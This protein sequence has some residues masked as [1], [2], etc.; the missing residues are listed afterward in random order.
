MPP[1]TDDD[2]GQDLPPD[3][4]LD[5]GTDKAKFVKAANAGLSAVVRV[6]IAGIVCECGVREDFTFYKVVVEV[7]EREPKPTKELLGK[8]LTAGYKK[9]RFK[10]EWLSAISIGL[11]TCEGPLK[12]AILKLIADMVDDSILGLKKSALTPDIGVEGDRILIIYHDWGMT[13]SCKNLLEEE[14]FTNIRAVSDRE[15]GL[16]AARS[17]KPDLIILG[18]LHIPSPEGGLDFCR[19]LHALPETRTARLMVIT[20]H[21]LQEY[22]TELFCCGVSVYIEKPFDPEK[23]IMTVKEMLS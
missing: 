3:D 11:G 15:E 23:F 1:G 4:V 19:Q 17:F 7:G 13:E 18:G 5:C 9:G 21:F 10:A 6:N 22:V 14:G 16:R 8:S 12:E 20:G 2:E